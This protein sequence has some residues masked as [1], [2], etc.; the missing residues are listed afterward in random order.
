MQRT[1][2]SYLGL[3]APDGVKRPD[4]PQHQRMPAAR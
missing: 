2:K 1:A 4:A 3:L